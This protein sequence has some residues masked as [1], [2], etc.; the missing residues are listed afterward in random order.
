M[1]SVSIALA[2]VFNGL[3]DVEKGIERFTLCTT[4]NLWDSEARAAKLPVFLEGGADILYIYIY[5]YM[6]DEALHIYI[7]IYIY[8]CVCVCVCVCV[9]FSVCNV[10]SHK[11]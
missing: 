5:V 3:P 4:A 7:Y 9:C 10:Q 11:D 1:V 8:M 2:S 6:C